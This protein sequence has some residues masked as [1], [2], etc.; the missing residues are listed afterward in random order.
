[1]DQKARAEQAAA[2]LAHELA[3]AKEAANAARAEARTAIE[4]AAELRGA[5][6][7]S[8]PAL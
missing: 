8:K 5:Q 4:H 6:A 3:D 2:Q 7:A 1:M